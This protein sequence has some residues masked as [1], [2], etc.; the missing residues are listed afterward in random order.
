MAINI[1]VDVDGTLIDYDDNPR[2][3][4][5]QLVKSLAKNSHVTLYC[6]SGGGHDYARMWA[7]RLKIAHLFKGF[8]T[9]LITPPSPVDITIDDEEITLGSVNL[10][11]K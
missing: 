6:W 11:I 4:I 5:I 9:K 3:P 7:E 8:A 1:Y 10:R 2:K